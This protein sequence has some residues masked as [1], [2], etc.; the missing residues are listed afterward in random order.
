MIIKLLQNIYHGIHSDRNID[1]SLPRERTTMLDV[2]FWPL[3]QVNLVDK[4][5]EQI[6]NIIL[7][8]INVST[9]QYKV[10][11]RSPI[12]QLKLLSLIN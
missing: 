4:I 2:S 9:Q 6:S 11:D 7:K 5:I 8:L 10:D 3:I 1:R 12:L